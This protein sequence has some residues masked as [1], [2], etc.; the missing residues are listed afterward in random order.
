MTR[1]LVV[2]RQ[3]PWPLDDGNALRVLEL[4]RH[5]DSDIECHLACLPYSVEGLA[6]LEAMGVFDSII[7]L[8]DDGGQR[9]WRRLIRWGNRDYYRIAHPDQFNTVQATLRR[10]IR[11]R[12]IDVLVAILERCEECSRNI[13]GTPRIVDQYDCMT[14]AHERQLGVRKR[15]EFGERLRWQH[16]IIMAKSVEQGLGNRCDLITA[17]APPDVSRLQQLNPGAAVAR[18]P[19]GISQEL[20]DRRPVRA[21]PRRAVAFWGNLSFPVNR[22]A[23]E[24][25]IARVWKPYLA[26]R[27]VEFVI[28]GPHA[29]RN[30][31]A[32][33]AAHPG[34]IMAGFVDDLFGYLDQYPIMVNP[35]VTGGGLKNKVLEAFATGLAVVTTSMGVDAFPEVDQSHCAISDDPAHQA[36]A[37]MDL[38]DHPRR[39]QAR[40]E[41]ARQ[42]VERHYTWRAVGANWSALIRDLA[43]AA[44]RQR[45][46]G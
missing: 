4:A 31:Q 11:E 19:N 8:P 14:L 40:V 12:G 20:L 7:M 34:V 18:V 2:N 29:D 44:A 1:V 5:R 41:Q 24:Y 37:I 38:L 10:T 16:R 23:I 3:V 43:R 33:V 26:E 17:I 25:F 6:D 15:T 45:G 36:S 13:A 9:S 39:R 42:L 27:N 32:L 22:Q 28:V 35:M 30:L 46:D 21:E